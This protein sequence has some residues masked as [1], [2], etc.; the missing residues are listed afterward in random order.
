MKGHNSSAEGRERKKKAQLS[1]TVVGRAGKGPT[2]KKCGER[3]TNGL[4]VSKRNRS[5]IE[6][7]V[8]HES[9]RIN[10]SYH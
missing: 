9:R 2:T 1:V 4:S 7:S 3:G 6:L 5:K 8:V 10:L